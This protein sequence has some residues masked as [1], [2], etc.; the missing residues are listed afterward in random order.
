MK[1]NTIGGGYL[2]YANEGDAGVDLKAVGNYIVP[3]HGGHVPWEIEDSFAAQAADN[4]VTVVSTGVKVAIPQGY[5]GIIVPRS[6]LAL[7][8]GIQVINTP[9]IIDSGYRGEIKVGLINH[10]NSDYEISEGDR[11]AQLIIVPYIKADFVEVEKLN[12]TSRGDGGF[13]STGIN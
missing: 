8:R 5:M 11:I 12:S 4:N 10:G 3:V 9:G 7:K 6:G 1:I 13:G 2:S